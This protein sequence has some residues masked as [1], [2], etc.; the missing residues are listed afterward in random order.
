MNA[1]RKV[2]DLDERQ[3]KR[4]RAWVGRGKKTRGQYELDVMERRE[5]EKNDERQR[6]DDD[7]GGER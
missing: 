6:K 7:E 2:K 5:E 4:Q 3:A 1:W